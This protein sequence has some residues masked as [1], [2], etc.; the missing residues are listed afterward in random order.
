MPLSRSLRE[1]SVEAAPAPSAGGRARDGTLTV[2]VDAS[3]YVATKAGIARYLDGMISEMLR[4]DPA[5]E[6]I[7]YA[8][9]PV[10]IALPPGRWRLRTGTGLEGRFVNPWVQTQVPRWAREDGLD[11][12]WGQNNMLPLRLRRPCFRI[13]TVHDLVP[14]VCPRTLRFTSVLTRRYYL[15]RACRAADAVVA[16]SD[17]TARD[18]VRLLGVAPDKVKRVYFGASDRFCPQPTARA[19]DVASGKYGLP[20]TYLLSVGTIEPRKHHTTLLAALA[21]L[22]QTP[23]LVIV[24]GVGWKAESAMREIAA[25]E[26][27]GRVRHLGRVDDVDLPALYAAAR[28]FVFPSVYEGF[29]LPVLEAMACGCPVLCSWSSSLPEVGGSAARYFRTGDSRDLA[30]RLEELLFDEE[31]LVAMVAAGLARA[32]Q[33]SFRQAAEEVLGIMKAGARPSARGLPPVAKSLC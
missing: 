28:L 27:A 15:A 1:P 4:Q 11:V 30:R 10:E 25:M 18:I 2:G 17:S 31:Q 32:R 9:R 7:F 5:V 29:G 3:S 21:L 6:F 23:L 20:E 26:R 14:F 16:D 19:K 8:P 12:F 13:L 24:G 33:F 22:P